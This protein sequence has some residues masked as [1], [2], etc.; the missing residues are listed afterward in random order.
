MEIMKSRKE[1][2]IDF[3][4]LIVAGDIQAAYDKYIGPDFRHHNPYFSGDRQSLLDGMKQNQGQFA[5]KV[6]EVLH[7]LEDGDFVVTHARLILSP[8]MPEIGVV[9]LYRFDNDKIVEEWDLSQQL[10][11][12]SPNK[13]G[14][15]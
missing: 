6:F 1:I 14:F 12:D 11:E 13:N 15:F 7:A 5:K 10:P 9:H 3:E 4:K 8:G 2:C